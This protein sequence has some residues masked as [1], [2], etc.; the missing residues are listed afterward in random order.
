MVKENTRKPAKHPGNDIFRFPKTNPYA[1]HS[2]S[3]VVQIWDQ[4]QQGKLTREKLT[5]MKGDGSMDVAMYFIGFGV[6]ANPLHPDN[7]WRSAVEILKFGK[8][9]YYR[10]APDI[11]M[12]VKDHWTKYGRPP[13]VGWGIFD[14][15]AGSAVLKKTTFRLSSV[16][17]HP[18]NPFR[19][20]S[21]YARLVDIIAA[22]GPTGIDGESWIQACC[23]ASRK[24]RNL[25]KND[26]AVIKSARPGHK[27]HQSC[28]E[29][30]VIVE[31]G[32]RFSIRFE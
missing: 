27:R 20:E 29:G 30:F 25:V 8:D 7:N 2:K 5:L 26:L 15:S 11:P 13:E 23:K 31:H 19:A 12:A 14:A 17:R 10:L 22:A 1:P 21:N 4:L 3:E 9:V 32:G 24:A 28:R 6:V 16:T 18:R